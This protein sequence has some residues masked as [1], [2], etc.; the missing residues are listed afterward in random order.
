[1]PEEVVA[2]GSSG[3]AGDGWVEV[4]RLQAVPVGQL[5]QVKVGRIEIVLAN[6]DGVVY[7]LEDVCSHQDFPLSD[8][9][10]EGTEL[11]CAF[12]GA[13]FDVCT[14]NAT[15]LPAVKAVRAFDVEDRDGAVFVRVD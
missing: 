12:H 14:G 8:G 7:A 2:D 13:K 4:A 11:E 6:V 5:L 1:M 15:Q 9:E 3:A 10:L